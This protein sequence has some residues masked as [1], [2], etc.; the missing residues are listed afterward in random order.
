MNF[1]KLLQKLWYSPGS[2]CQY[3]GVE[4]LYECAKKQQNKIKK[5][6]VLSWLMRQ[7]LYTRTKPTVSKFKR[8]QIVATIDSCWSADLMDMS[9]L[10][11]RNSYYTFVLVCV[12]EF[13]RYTW[14]EPIKHKKPID[15]KNAFQAILTRS[16]RRPTSLNM[17]NGL[18]FKNKL[19]MD[20]FKAKSI[21][22]YFTTDPNIK[23]SLAER[24]IR[25]LKG[26]IY[27][28]CLQ[29]NTWR[30]VDQLQT[31]V[32]GLN[33]RTMGVLGGL[34][35]SEVTPSNQSELYA[36]MYSKQFD[37]QTPYSFYVGET[38]RIPIKKTKFRKSFDPTYSQS[39]FTVSQRLKTLPH[40]YRLSDSKGHVLNRNFYSR[41]LIEIPNP[42]E[43]QDVLFKSRPKKKVICKSKNVFSKL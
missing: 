32:E 13:S 20:Y 21:H 10:K 33:Q 9:A 34:S 30:Y 19:L 37:K 6:D 11:T 27:K 12:D 35:P 2:P 31:I 16:K 3:A 36:R 18:E 26:I 4:P 22:M 28:Y 43:Q 7:P 1:N 39:L 25:T 14:C 42:D 8:R 23:S 41:E 17:D 29:N 38:V 40:T 15:V 24:T 5:M